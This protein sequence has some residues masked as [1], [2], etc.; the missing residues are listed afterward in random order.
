MADDADRAQSRIEEML[1]DAL[2]D[3][4][5]LMPQGKSAKWC[6]GVGGANCGARIPEARRRVIP[7]V[8][9]CVDCAAAKEQAEMRG[10]RGLG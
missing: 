4:R 8:Q 1:D 2:A 5:R 9:V 10:A 7:G 6:V 3:N